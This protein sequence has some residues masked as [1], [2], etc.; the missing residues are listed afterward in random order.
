MACQ[1]AKLAL[2]QDYKR[3]VLKI[4]SLL[5]F[6]SKLKVSTSTIF[7]E[8]A[9]TIFSTHIF[10]QLTEQLL[11]LSLFSY[12]G[13]HQNIVFFC[14][15][16]SI[17][18]HK[19]ISRCCNLFLKILNSNSQKVLKFNP[20]P[21]QSCRPA[22]LKKSIYNIIKFSIQINKLSSSLFVWV[23]QIPDAFTS[24]CSTT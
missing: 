18:R 13:M 11:F 1:N 20:V 21:S 12:M 8:S 22:T 6:A 24:T 17:K 10:L 14:Q 19:N 4:Y 23:A 15:S 3:T 2:F 9:S 7:L 16:C 5:S